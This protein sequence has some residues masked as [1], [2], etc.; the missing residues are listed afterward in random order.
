MRV[1]PNLPPQLFHIRFSAVPLVRT[2]S[3]YSSR[4]AKALSFRNTCSTTCLSRSIFRRR[5]SSKNLKNQPLKRLPACAAGN[6]GLQSLF[7]ATK[8]SSILSGVS[9]R[10]ICIFGAGLGLGFTL[11]YTVQS[12]KTGSNS[13]ED[14]AEEYIDIM[15][16]GILPGRPGN[17]TAEQEEKLRQLW[18]LIFQV[19][20]IAVEKPS[21]EPSKLE[22]TPTADT[23]KKAKKSRM[24][25][26]R[27][28]KKDSDA[29]ST[30]EAAEK[31]GAPPVILGNHG[32]EDKHGQVKHFYDT[33][34][35]QSPEFLRQT[36]WSMV[37]H[38]HPDALALRFLRARKWDVE[39]ALIMFISTINWRATDMKVDEDIM[40]NGEAAALAAENGSDPAAKTLGH[41]F[42]AQ[43]RMGKSYLHGCDKQGR[44]ICVVRVRLHKAGEQ[45]EE[46]LERYTVY[47]I[48]TTR[49]LLNPPV[50]TAVSLRLFSGMLRWFADHC[51]RQFSLI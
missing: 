23:S 14:P 31:A 30:S 27:R 41:D 13:P 33:L 48:E 35:T 37:K 12:L 45:V 29:D 26:L 49:M 19:C 24:G 1:S 20:G 39:K 22:N 34:S 44:P 46:S 40:R 16:T 10:L 6:K 4:C 28:G 21:D 2:N 8:Y 43:M 7:L 36:I 15:S 17:L 42:L 18:Q 5:P 25:F 38:D 11:V 50:D 32:D 47:L 51:H 9:L 3:S